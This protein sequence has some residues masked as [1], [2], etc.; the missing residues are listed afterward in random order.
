MFARFTMAQKFYMAF[1]ALFILFSLFGLHSYK[2]SA[3]LY[4]S[5]RD[6]ESWGSISHLLSELEANLENYDSYVSLLT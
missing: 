2:S 3:V 6:I 5:A 4:Q 1:G